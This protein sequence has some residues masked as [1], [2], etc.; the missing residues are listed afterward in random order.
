MGTDGNDTFTK[1][2]RTGWGARLKNAL[3]GFI[4]GPIL[5]IGSIW[6]LAWN[7][8]RSAEAQAALNKGEREVVAVSP[9]SI[10]KSLEGKLVYITGDAATNETLRDPMFGVE[11]NA[12]WLQ[13]DTDMYQWQE[14]KDSSS[15]K[16]MGGSETTTTTYR[17]SKIWSSSLIRSSSFEKPDGHANPNEFQRIHSSLTM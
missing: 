5:I 11:K 8:G 10:N 14:E 6:A 12:L 2:T 17:Y 13:R 1:T 4:I 3:A 16:Y 7:E 15:E 9:E